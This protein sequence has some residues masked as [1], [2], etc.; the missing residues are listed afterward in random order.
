MK[1]YAFT[2]VLEPDEEGWHVYFPPWSKI[3]A[4]TWGATREE[5]LY[6]IKEVL[7]MI[8]EEFDEEG[9]PLPP[10][11]AEGPADGVPVSITV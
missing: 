3:G 7:E 8:I 6:Y 10:V 1:T 5:A 4:S 9:T 11:E 2:V